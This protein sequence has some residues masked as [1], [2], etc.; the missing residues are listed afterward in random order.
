MTKTKQFFGLMSGL[1]YDYLRAFIVLFALFCIPIIAEAQISLTISKS[2]NAPPAIQSGAPFTYTITYSWSGG[3][4]GTLYI[5]DNVPATLE[6]ISALPSS[7]ISTISGNNVTFALTGLTLPSGSGTVQINARFKPG[8]TCGGVRA[9]NRA[10]ISLTN[11]GQYIYSNES[12]VTSANP[13]NRWSM[14][15]EWIA[16]CAINDAVIYRIKITAP[17]GNDIGGV[18][19]TNVSLQDLLPANAVITSVAGSWS[20]YTGSNPYTLNGPTTLYVSP[21]PVWYTAYVTVQ[22]PSAFFTSGQTV[23]NSA[24]VQ[25]N[26][27]CNSNFVT[28]TDTAKTVLCAGVS[29]G[30]VYKWLTLGLSFPNNPSYYPVWTPGC[31]GTYSL[32]YSNTGTLSQPGF[33]MEDVLPGEVDVNKI[34]T[35][36]PSSN[37]PVTVDVYCWSGTSCS[38]TPCTT[39]VY[40]TA[41]YFDMTGLPPNICKVKWSYSGSIAVSQALYNYLDVCVRSTNFMT[42]AAVLPSQ[43][44]INTLNVSA[45]NLSL[46]TTNHTKP[47]DVTQPKIV[48]TKIFIGGCNP[49][50]SVNPNGPFQ[51]GDI[52]RY[53]MAVANIGNQNATTCTITD[54][55]PAGV[56][57][58]GNETYFYGS[59]NW[60]VSQYNPPCCS[61]TVTVPAQVGGSITS[62]TVGASNLTWTF[63]VLPSR[64]DGTVDYFIIEF[65]VKISDTPP[66][67]PGQYNNT[68]TI[69]ASNHANV[70]S[71]VAIF[72]VNQTAQL[73]AIKEVRTVDAGGS[74]T[75]WAYTATVPPGGT[76]EYRIK[77]V[78]T[79]NSQLTGLCLLDIMPWVNDIKVLPPYN[80]RGSNLFLPYNPSAGAIAIT[81]TGYTATF[82]NLGLVQSQNPTR[83]TECGGFCGVANPGGAVTGT[84]TSAPVTTFSFKVTA[85][86]GVNLMPGNTLN[87]NIPFEIPKQAIPQSVG[88]N[89]FGVQAVPLNMANVCLSA[90]SNNACVTVGDKDPCIKVVEARIHC[91]SK[92]T[93]GNWIYQ[94]TFNATNLTPTAAIVNLFPSSG[95]IVSITPAALPSGVPT[96]FTVIY[97]TNT[98]TGNVCFNLWLYDQENM[99]LCDTTMCFDIEPCPE[100]CPCPFN[101]KMDKTGAWSASGNQGYFQ[102]SISVSTPVL[103]IRASVVSATVTQTCWWGGSTTY[104]TGATFTAASTNPVLTQ[105]I[106]TSELTYTN[107]QCPQVNNQPF[108]FYL[109]IPNAPSKWCYQN[110][111]VCVRYTITD[112]K[113]NTCDTLVCYEFTRKWTPIIWHDDIGEIKKG[114]SGTD[115]KSDDK[116]QITE[117][118]F[119][120]MSMTDET[121]G[122]L[123]VNNPAEDEFTAGMTIHAVSLQPATGVSVK[124]MTPDNRSWNSGVLTEK[125]MK[126][127]GVLSPGNSISFTVEFENSA[128]FKQWMNDVYIEH[129]V[130]NV[131]DTLIGMMQIKARTPGASGGD[132]ISQDYNHSSSVATARTFALRFN[133]ENLSSDSISR[134]VL[135]VKDGTILAVGPQ[136]DQGSATVSGYFTAGGQWKLLATSP[137]E[138]IAA[139]IPVPVGTAIE[140]VYLTAIS[141]S[142]EFV[143]I[144]FETYTVDEELVSE[145]SLRIETP[146]TGIDDDGVSEAIITLTEAIPNPAQNMTI[147][148][149]NLQQDEPM[150][151][152]VVTDAR[153]AIVKTLITSSSYQSGEH[154][155]LFDTS[156]LTNGVYYYT[157]TTGG[158]TQTRRVVVMR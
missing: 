38:A 106:G 31:C 157:L 103:Q 9:C 143:E 79:G 36:V 23:V 102:N 93:N 34:K 56:T 15:K 91:V 145:G 80:P 13:V 19:L 51:P 44:V 59:Y 100:P 135:R 68:F 115:K 42:G 124:S 92:G 33:V 142:E 120:E 128:Q 70:T 140:P 58:V 114:T 47:V 132:M 30:N 108:N 4:P 35:Y 63:P 118:P 88:C 123:T 1:G 21:Y 73:Q 64:C 12:C 131:P 146:I 2:N 150:V 60:M 37:M 94:L 5:I 26:T 153:G 65:D 152:L 154:E 11:N 77:V 117:E 8:V 126:C 121:S 14:E 101:I 52:V 45:N 17:S 144:E 50:C 90:E 81:P 138:N 28:V 18:N 136:L 133:A 84:F 155:V 86:S 67:P 3:A 122:I 48:A 22:Y 39:V 61:T 24:S 139:M 149:F 46:V 158:A 66:A 112:C 62:P 104:T 53:R 89:S 105:G 6:V 40:N 29:S 125:G 83:S 127:T 49:P 69:G 137:N 57:Y 41:G 134:V 147:F 156:Q 141:S 75:P 87:V 129:T 74:P 110:V 116:P 85:N 43:N 130:D 113:C 78:N 16:G 95:S 7:P 98:P 10:G 76:G 111:K 55:L 148:K 96:N 151:S 99:E 20:S 25:Y 72:T 32:Y 97:Q 71:N 27:P 107:Y 82:N 109:N 54:N 119:L